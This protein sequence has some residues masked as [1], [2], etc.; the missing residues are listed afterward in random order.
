MATTRIIAFFN[1]KAGVK[2]ADYDAIADDYR[3][4]LRQAMKETA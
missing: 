2:V 3:A 4:R 1:L